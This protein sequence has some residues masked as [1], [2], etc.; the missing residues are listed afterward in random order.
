MEDLTSV[1][2]TQGAI[3]QHARALAAGEIG[4]RYAALP[5]QVRTE[6]VTHTDD[7]GWRVAEK[8]AFQLKPWTCR[9]SFLGLKSGGL[10]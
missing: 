9:G 2:L 3:T 7:T 4:T 5:D 8:Q 10:W 6:P 1:R